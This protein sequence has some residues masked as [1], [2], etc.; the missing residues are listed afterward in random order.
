MQSSKTI[1][2]PWTT[3]HC[4]STTP[5]F[6]PVSP[7]MSAPDIQYLRCSFELQARIGNIQ[8]Q[9]AYQTANDPRSPD[10]AVGFGDTVSTEGFEDPSDHEDVGATFKAR[11]LYRLGFLC[12][13]TS[14]STLSLA[15]V[16]GTLMTVSR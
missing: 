16:T 9:A 7:F 10:T 5:L 2:V 3:V 1:H 6:I 4:A 8:V 15:R 11:Q 12:S 13:N 14:G